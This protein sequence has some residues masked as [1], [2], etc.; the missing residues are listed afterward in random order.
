MVALCKYFTRKRI[1]FQVIGEVEERDHR[2]EGGQR[3]EGAEEE[4]EEIEIHHDYE[5]VREYIQKLMASNIIG[6]SQT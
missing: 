3:N 5:E 1:R 4:L 6:G 2:G